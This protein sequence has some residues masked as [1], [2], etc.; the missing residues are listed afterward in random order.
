[1]RSITALAF[2]ALTTAA[3]A[4]TA[5]QSINALAEN[6]RY[7]L[8]ELNDR[9][10]RLDTAVGV[11]DLCGLENGAWQ[12]APARDRA[13]TLT[14]QIAALTQRVEA[15]EAEVAAQKTER[16]KGLVG[17]ITDYVPGLK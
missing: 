13:K 15:L 10:L 16:E 2:L 12:C 14:D 7:Q 8:L 9:I 4:Q 6:G 17:R 5:P 1:M 11:F 3:G